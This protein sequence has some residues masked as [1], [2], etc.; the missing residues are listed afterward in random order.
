[1]RFV[2]SG[3]GPSRQA[4]IVAS[5]LSRSGWWQLA[6]AKQLPAAPL[7][8]F[9]L[10]LRLWPRPTVTS[11]E[12]ASAAVI[13]PTARAIFF[14]NS[15]QRKVG[16]NHQCKHWSAPGA[17]IAFRAMPRHRLRDSV[18][19]PLSRVA[20]RAGLGARYANVQA[21]ARRLEAD[22][23]LVFGSAGLDDLHTCKSRLGIKHCWRVTESRP[24]CV[25]VDRDAPL[26][27][28]RGTGVAKLPK[29]QSSSSST[30]RATARKSRSSS[31]N[32]GRTLARSIAG[33]VTGNR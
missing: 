9:G 21:C 13:K 4:L 11:S 7:P 20:R 28:A 10:R 8:P 14:S 15:T 12:A 6:T 16:L 32:G 3:A 30:H 26:V 19:F 27:A 23:P 5:W 22:P 18:P 17:P 25:P 2:L 1:M 33:S 29:L 31:S 24:N